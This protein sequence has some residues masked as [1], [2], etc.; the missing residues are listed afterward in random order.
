MDW[1]QKNGRLKGYYKHRLLLFIPC[2]YVLLEA[3]TRNWPEVSHIEQRNLLPLFDLSDM[4]W[5]VPILDGDRL[6]KM[7]L[8]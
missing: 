4:T 3:H 1:S 8:R 7:P 6:L 2:V 5:R